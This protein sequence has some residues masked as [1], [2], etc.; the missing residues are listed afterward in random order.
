MI[1]RLPLYKLIIHGDG[2]AT[3]AKFLLDS[4]YGNSAGNNTLPTTFAACQPFQAVLN[5]HTSRKR[6]QIDLD[7]DNGHN[8]DQDSKP[9]SSGGAERYSGSNA[10]NSLPD[11]NDSPGQQRNLHGTVS[12]G[13]APMSMA[14][15]L[16]LFALPADRDVSNKLN[17][18]DMVG[19]QAV[20]NC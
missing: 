4:I 13:G 6:V 1:Q 12:G 2:A 17:L 14:N 7:G 10:G 20:R 15:V 8:P 16:S 3:E 5:D 19:K 9:S 18:L 11:R